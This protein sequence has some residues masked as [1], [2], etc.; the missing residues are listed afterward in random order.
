MYITILPSRGRN[1]KLDR[2]I[3]LKTH[4]TAGKTKKEPPAGFFLQTV[5]RS[6]T[7]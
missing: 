7:L 4:R 3:E 2:Y 6:G 5:L 1:G